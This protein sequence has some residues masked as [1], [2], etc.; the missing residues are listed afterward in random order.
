M[1]AVIEIPA[2]ERGVVR[3]FALSLTD[4]QVKS[5]RDSP[6]A[7]AEALGTGEL[8]ERDHVV[9]VPMDDI[10]EIGLSGYLIEGAGIAETQ[11]AA[12]RA[13]LDNL[14]GWVLVL[15]SLAF[16]DR[17]A[18]LRPASSLTLIG[19]YG[20]VRTDWSGDGALTSQSAAPGTAPP[21][22][23]KKRPSDA[24]MSGRIATIVLIGLGLFT[25]IFIRIAG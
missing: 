14:S 19:T 22:T 21:E 10:A 12:D 17:P 15:Y 13:K 2:R 9:F 24:A 11:V 25:Y 8:L 20:E 18:T 3:V 5:L 7:V 16:A 4:A 23:V 6:E 1:S